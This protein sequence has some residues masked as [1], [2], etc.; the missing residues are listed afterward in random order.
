VHFTRQQIK[1]AP[2]YAHDTAL[3]EAT[4]QACAVSTA[5]P[6][7]GATRS[8]APSPEAPAR[9]HSAHDQVARRVTPTIDATSI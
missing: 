4:S 6:A 5:A 1:D 3:A 9:R 7:I 2:P 8:G